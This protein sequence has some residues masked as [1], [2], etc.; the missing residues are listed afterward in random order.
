M[1]ANASFPLRSRDV[2]AGTGLFTVARFVKNVLPSERIAMSEL[3]CTGKECCAVCSSS[4]WK[5]AI[6]KCGRLV[7]RPCHNEI[8]RSQRKGQPAQQSLPL[9]QARQP[10]APRTRILESER[11]GD[12]VQA[13]F[14]VLDGGSDG[15]A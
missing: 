14:G 2:P 11:W 6:W 1:A 9:A 4:E 5:D 7:C 15:T 8:L 10:Q 12:H 3:T 13:D